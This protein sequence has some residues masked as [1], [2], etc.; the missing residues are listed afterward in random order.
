LRAGKRRVEQRVSSWAGPLNRERLRLA[1][2][3][4]PMALAFETIGSA[5]CIGRCRRRLRPR[6][7]VGRWAWDTAAV[8]AALSGRRLRARARAGDVAIT[9]TTRSP[10]LLALHDTAAATSLLD[11]RFRPCRRSGLFCSNNRAM[12]WRSARW[13][14]APSWPHG[15]ATAR[16]ATRWGNAVIA[17]WNTGDPP[18]APVVERYAD[19]RGRQSQLRSALVL[20]QPPFD[21]G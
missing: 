12:G 18:L 4:G 15:R 7:A 5:T 2:L 16:V 13:R 17:L 1:V 10:I 20:K 19:F 21:R 3:H 9:G 14:C 8:R 11:L 6:D